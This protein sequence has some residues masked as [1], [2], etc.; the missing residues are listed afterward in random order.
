MKLRG[1]NGVFMLAVIIIF[2]PRYSGAAVF[3]IKK[4]SK[5][6]FMPDMTAAKQGALFARI[7]GM[8]VE[9][10]SYSTLSS[11]DGIMRSYTNNA[12]MRGYELMNGKAISRLGAFLVNM[13]AAENPGKWYYLMY[14]KHDKNIEM[15]T[16]G[17]FAG[18]TRITI[19]KTGKT[20]IFSG[21]KGFNDG[22]KPCPGAVKVLSIEILSGNSVI[23]F[24]NLYKNL[25]SDRFSIMVF[26]KRYFNN[27]SWE[28]QRQYK[29]DGTDMFMIEKGGKEYLL[30][31]YPAEGNLNWIMVIGKQAVVKGG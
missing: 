17:E 27:D 31:I 4:I 3:D 7:N 16:A 14:K 28:I 6:V 26:Y 30:N 1:I 13:G 19:A 11:A 9:I 25:S 8:P 29:D 24:A 22:L 10:D 20:N 2:W 23:G 21:L 15:V 5:S 12:R 18:K